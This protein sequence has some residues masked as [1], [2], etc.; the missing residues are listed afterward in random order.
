MRPEAAFLQDILLSA[1]K[2]GRLIEGASLEA[3]SQDDTTQAALLYHLVI[4]G[5]A[6]NK[7]PGALLARYPEVPWHAVVALRNRVIHGYFGI[8]WN[9]IWQIVTEHLPALREIVAR[10]LRE[11]FGAKPEV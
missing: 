6:V 11:E 4:I 5:E 1:G 10:I 8:D 2:I 3:L 7:L 9:L